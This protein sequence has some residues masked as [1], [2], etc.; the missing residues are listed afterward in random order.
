MEGLGLYVHWPYCLSKCPY[1]DF[2]SH[3]AAEVPAARW[4]AAIIRELDHY[5]AET[6]ALGHVRTIFFGGGTP[7]LMPPEAAGAVIAHAKKLWGLA[8]H[9]EITLEANPTSVEAGRLKAFRGAGVNR[10]SLGVQALDDGALSALGRKHTAAEAVAAL[11][12]AAKSVP[13]VSFDLIYARPG[14]TVAAW[15]EE[16]AKA[17]DLAHGHL[18]LYQLT[19]E[20]GTLFHRDKVEP[21]DEDASC[22]MFELTQEMTAKAGLPA[23]EISNHARPGN[24]CRHNLVYWRGGDYVGV[25]PGAHGRIPAGGQTAATHQIHDPARWLESVEKIGHGAGKRTRLS[26]K[27]RADELLIAGLRLAQGVGRA[28]FRERAGL[29]LLD[30]VDRPALRRLE[31]GGFLVLDEHVL[32][33]TPAGRIRLNAILTSLLKS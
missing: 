15:R 1:C 9:A 24:E 25:G 7:S 19:I 11:R 3:A 4:Q 2:N 21:A 18:S 14:Q 6:K 8:D 12:T 30:A 27:Q 13:R 20:P 28:R 10:V 23:Y 17:L 32:R 5:H 33:A 31:D 16:L 26:P 22:D 29:D